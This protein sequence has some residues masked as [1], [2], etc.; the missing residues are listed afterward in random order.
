MKLFG[1]FSTLAVTLLFSLNA[2][3]LNVDIRAEAAILMNADTGEI[4]YEKNAYTPMYPASITKVATAAYTLS[5]KSK[6]LNAIVTAEGE[7]LGWVTDEAKKKS[8]YTLPSYRLEPAGTHMGI[9]KGEQLALKELLFGLMLVSANDAANVI[10]MHVGKTVPDFMVGL[11][12]YLKQIGCAQTHF[13]N[14]HG[15]H[16]PS[17]VTTAYDMA[18]LARE[19]IK[20]PIF[21][22]IVSSVKH[23]RPQTNKQEPSPLL[24]SNKLLRSGKFYYAKAT[25][26]K[27]GFHSAAQNTIIASAKHDNRTLIAVLLKEKERPDL[28]EDTTALFEAAFK[29][30]KVQKMLV[31]AGPQKIARELEGASGPVLTYVAENV[32]LDYYP[33]EEPAIR[34]LLTWDNI[35]PPVAANQKVGELTIETKQGRLIKRVPLYAAEDVS[36]SWNYSLGTFFGSL[37][38]PATGLKIVGGLACFIVLFGIGRQLTKS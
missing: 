4:L 35:Q 7:A 38:Q 36:A 10:A 25:G 16:D 5:L 2:Q 8:N 17:H 6:E 27:T 28:F 37:E 21:C 24:Q 30:P 3:Q 26:V 13:A 31:K 15:L 1:Y 12:A 14:P 19:A 22:Q 20:N 18:L 23:T 32:T 34:S 29:Q 11:N 9:K 33:A